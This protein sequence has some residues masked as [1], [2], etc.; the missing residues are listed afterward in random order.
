M[1]S[2]FDKYLKGQD[3]HLLDDPARLFP[4]VINFA[5]K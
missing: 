1:L 4:E 5:R 2:F 3:D